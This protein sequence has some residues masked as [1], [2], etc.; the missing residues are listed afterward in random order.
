MIKNVAI[1]V[2]RAARTDP[3]QYDSVEC[4]QAS[5][6]DTIPGVED[7][8]HNSAWSLREFAQWLKNHGHTVV[9]TRRNKADNGWLALCKPMPEDA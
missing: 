3:E 8:A 9:A 1:S 6:L 2:W 5:D 4:I 7:K